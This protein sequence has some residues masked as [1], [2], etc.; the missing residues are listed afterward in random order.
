MNI[1]ATDAGLPRVA[2]QD[3]A[4]AA[5][6]LETPA[7]KKLAKAVQE[8]EGILISQLLGDFQQGFSAP[9][10][11]PALAGADSL[12]SLAI[13]SLSEALARRGG[14]GI[15]SMLMRQLDRSPSWREPEAAGSK[16]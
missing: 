6:P 7:H 14:L 13:H 4:N 5:S 9:G 15:G 3:T 8:F 16:D 2:G 10:G 12:N 1:S 11:Q